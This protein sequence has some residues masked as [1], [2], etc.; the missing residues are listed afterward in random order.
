MATG[1]SY[2]KTNAINTDTRQVAE[3]VGWLEEF[4]NLTL[5]LTQWEHCSSFRDDLRSRSSSLVQPQ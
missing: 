2:I 1:I 4:K 3:Q 5:W